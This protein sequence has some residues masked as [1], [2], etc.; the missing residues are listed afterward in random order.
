M[1]TRYNTAALRDLISAALS[2]DEFT[3]LAFD[4]FRPVYDQFAAGQTR[5]QRVQLLLEHAVRSGQMA[6]LA[7]LIQEINP[8]RYREFADR[9][10]ASDADA[11]PAHERG[12]LTMANRSMTSEFS[13]GYALLIGVGESAYPRWSLPVTVKDM[14]ALRAILTDP[15]LCGYPDGDAHI[16]LLHDAGATRQA[17]LDGL[18]WLARQTASDS[19]ATAVVFYSGHG[20]VAD[21]P[22]KYYLLPHNIEP[23][24]LAGS[25]LPA[26]DFTAALRQVGAKRLLVF[27]DSCHAAGMATAKD[28][29]AMKLP[30]GFT[31]TALPKGLVEELKQGTGRAVF[32]SSTGSQQS[33]VR[34]DG[35]LSLYTYHLIEALR[36]AGN[37]PGD[38]TVR[39]SN[40][41]SHLGK[42]VPESARALCQAEQTPFF[43]T[44]TEDFAVAL[45]LGGKGLGGAGFAPAPGAGAS[46]PAIQASGERSVAAGTISDS[47]IVT[48]DRNTVQQGK[49]NISIG[50]V[51]GLVIGD[52]AQVTQVFGG[53][54]SPSPG[55]DGTGSHQPPSG[56]AAKRH[57]RQ[58]LVELQG[59]YEML[60][61]RIAAL[62]T[63]L[64]RTLD[65]EHKLT[66]QERRQD[67]VAERNQVAGEMSQIEE[68]LQGL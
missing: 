29:P 37:Q 43:D 15:A 9:L 35:S 49:Y 52:Q 12:K 8:A 68:H 22:G 55:R 65:G 54:P 24:D 27:V 36:G 1:T 31:Q 62:D 25:A 53:E 67:L 46:Q 28:Q 45:L 38:T 47:P 56:D 5:N 23:F 40:L 60:S 51:Q 58:Q 16:R 61:K 17:I 13:H 7:A 21:D 32:S 41:M 66:L 2:E 20:W 57:L 44:A 34:P 19:D 39:V 33:W 6:R 63:D 14:Q 64:G 18:T 48:G 10:L 3:A 4:H 50:S 42:A 11:A 59:R 26:E 30:S